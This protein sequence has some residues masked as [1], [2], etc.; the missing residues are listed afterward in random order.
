MKLIA[1][2]VE[3]SEEAGFDPEIDIFGR[4]VFGEALLNLIRNT[5]DELVLALDAPWGG[6]GKSTFIKMWRGY[7]KSHEVSCV[8]FD[9]FENDYQADPFLAI[10]SE[11]YQLID[12][13]DEASIKSSEKKQL[14]LLR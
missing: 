14:L 1:P 6:E 5:E 7:L 11:I 10:S 12:D 8:Y 3:I 2:P 13:G 9:A 4:R